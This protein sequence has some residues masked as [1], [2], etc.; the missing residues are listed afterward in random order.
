MDRR[1]DVEPINRSSIR[2]RVACFHRHEY[3]PTDEMIANYEKDTGEKY[4]HRE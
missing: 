2:K 1:D 4:I 3:K